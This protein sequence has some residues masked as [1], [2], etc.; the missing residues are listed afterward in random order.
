M[1]YP[2]RPLRTRPPHAAYPTP[3][4]APLRGISGGAGLRH[5][6]L[7]SRKIRVLHIINNLNYGGM[8]RILA[9]IV[10]RMDPSRFDRHVLALSYLGQFA[11]GLEDVATLHIA[12]RMPPWSLLWPAR[13]T[14]QIQRIAP[15]VVHTHSGVW[16]KASLAAR[17]ARVPRLIHTEHGRPY[18]DSWHRKFLEYLA[19]KRTDILVTVSEP[20]HQFHLAHSILPEHHKLRIIVNGVDTDLYCP[21]PDPGTVRRELGIDAMTPVLGSIGRLQPIKGYDVMVT[22]FHRLHS[23]CK[24]G[25]T[26]LLV[27]VGDGAERPHLETLAA[28]YALHDKIRFLGWR[29]D[30]HDLHATFTLFTLSSRSEGTSVSLLEAMSSGLCPIVTNVG[31]NA[32]ILGTELRHRLIPPEDPVALANAWTSALQ[33]VEKRKRDAQAARSRVNAHFSLN[34]MVRSYEQLYADSC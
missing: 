29:D 11:Q 32:N 33:D 12:D 8:E 15:D 5:H 3:R 34:F 9:D 19:A 21:R 18:P 27:I 30:I 16:Y 20:L 31:G 7:M 28:S 26:P 25:P 24:S 22:A 2:T 13:L 14:R 23:D 17:L 1:R 4:H 6:P 10:R